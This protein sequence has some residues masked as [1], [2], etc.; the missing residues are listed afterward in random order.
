MRSLRDN[1][2]TTE[3][4]R[5]SAGIVIYDHDEQ[6]AAHDDDDAFGDGREQDFGGALPDLDDGHTSDHH[7][8]QPHAVS[9]DPAAFGGTYSGEPLTD[10]PLADPLAS[11]AHLCD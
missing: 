9:T 3:F 6:R 11:T 2:P 10:E 7:H 4:G 8:H 1:G 5:H